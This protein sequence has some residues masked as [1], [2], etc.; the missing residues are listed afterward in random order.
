VEFYL[1]RPTSCHGLVLNSE[2]DVPLLSNWVPS[3]G[4]VNSVWPW[5]G[6]GLNFGPEVGYNDGFSWSLSA[7]TSVAGRWRDI[8]RK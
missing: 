6:W 1:S 4:H 8:S 3:G 5:E 2:T 7:P